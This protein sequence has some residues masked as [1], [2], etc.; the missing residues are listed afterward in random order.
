ML[1][2]SDWR[3]SYF[4]AATFVGASLVGANFDHAQYGAIESYADFTNA[5]LTGATFVG[6]NLQSEYYT[7]ERYLFDGATLV[8][9]DFTDAIFSTNANK[10]V[11][12]TN[13]D[14]TCAVFTGDV[15]TYAIIWT[16]ATC[17]DGTTAD[18]T[19]GCDNK[20]VFNPASCP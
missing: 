16:G 5:D 19:D 7:N 6:A 2:G 20:L 13:A 14:L 18:P 8:N 4:E 17:P 1:D 15:S 12:F 9:A 10:W 11:S 3:D